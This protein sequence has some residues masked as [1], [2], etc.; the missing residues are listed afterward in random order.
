MTRI[1]PRSSNGQPGFGRMFP[2]QSRGWMRRGGWLRKAKPRF[3]RC[4]RI[5]VSRRTQTLMRRQPIS[6]RAKH[7][8]VFIVVEGKLIRLGALFGEDKTPGLAREPACSAPSSPSSSPYSSRMPGASATR[9]TATPA[10]SPNHLR[11]SATLSST[12]SSLSALPL[13]PSQALRPVSSP[14]T[15]LPPWRATPS[16]LSLSSRRGRSRHL[17]RATSSNTL[18]APPRALH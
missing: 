3:N 13:H 11:R 1:G 7:G 10:P 14:V 12:L 5:R 16:P 15:S 18:R 17:P 6:R 8:R 9:S 4:C 2:S